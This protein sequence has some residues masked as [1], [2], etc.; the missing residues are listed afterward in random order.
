MAYGVIRNDELYHHGILGQK[1]GIRR[2]QNKD[3]SV[4]PRGAKRYYDE[5]RKQIKADKK[6]AREEK[7]KQKA[8]NS[9]DSP[10]KLMKNKKYLTDEEFEKRANKFILEKQLK[11]C[12][13]SKETSIGR[14]AA[15][16]VATDAAATAIK[17]GLL[18]A[19]GYAV[20]KTPMGQEFINNSKEAIKSAKK[21]YSVTK[22]PAN[23]RK[24]VANTDAAKSYVQTVDKAVNAAKETRK[25]A[26][27]SGLGQ[28]YVKTAQKVAKTAPVRNVA[29][30]LG[31]MRRSAA[32]S[33]MGRRYVKAVRKIANR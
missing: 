20:S 31:S 16:K 14:Q 32:T 30:D 10:E 17:V 23:I 27:S 22:D 15:K 33:E 25:A 4:T 8:I 3:G 19:A 5:D 26:A 2:F 11:D 1:W 13:S 21:V 9:I 7:K 12:Y 24:V 28:A 29:K 18:V 6:A